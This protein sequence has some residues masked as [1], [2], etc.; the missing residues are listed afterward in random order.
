MSVGLSPLLVEKQSLVKAR[1]TLVLAKSAAMKGDTRLGV[2]R[3]ITAVIQASIVAA[4]SSTR[5][6]KVNADRVIQ[7]A[8]ELIM[9]IV[10]SRARLRKLG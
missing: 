2:S 6:T 10:V 5:E 3:A 1:K 4:L 9:G 7:G 8:R